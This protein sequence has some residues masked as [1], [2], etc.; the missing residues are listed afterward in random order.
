[1]YGK[2]PDQPTC[3]SE[4]AA[5]TRI[6][7]VPEILLNG[8]LV[9]LQSELRDHSEEMVEYVRLDP[10]VLFPYL[11]AGEEIDLDRHTVLG[12]LKLADD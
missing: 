3:R 2:N 4:R 5:S 7:P 1:M 8:E 6:T 11:V 9:N 10:F 12:G